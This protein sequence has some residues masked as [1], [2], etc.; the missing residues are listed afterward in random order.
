MEL[1]KTEGY[2]PLNFIS[3]SADDA[4]FPPGTTHSQRDVNTLGI[5]LGAQITL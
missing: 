3:G 2:A 1:F 4:H 5:V